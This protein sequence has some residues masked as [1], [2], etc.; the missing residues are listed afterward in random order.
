MSKAIDRNY[1]LRLFLAVVVFLI[2]SIG[3]AQQFDKKNSASDQFILRC[4]GSDVAAVVGRHG[5]ELVHQV[6]DGSQAVALVRSP[7]GV[8]T[9][10]LVN[11]LI[12]DSAVNGV[13]PAQV[14]SL[15]EHGALTQLEGS[16]GE[17]T[18]GLLSQGT[19]SSPCVDQEFSSPVWSGYADQWAAEKLNLHQAH[20][21]GN[22]C[23]NAVLAVID[24]GIDPEHE[25]LEGS[26]ISGFDFIL[27]EAGFASDWSNLEQS[28]TA[29]V[30]QSI[31][32]LVEQSIT[33]LVE[34]IGEPLV[35]E[36]SITA[37]VEQSIT[38]L[39]EG[40]TLPP[41]FGHGDRKSVV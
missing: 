14:A 19:F 15:P 12:L 13:E 22:D 1:P 24:T 10:D 17:L 5:L 21:A 40:E 11:S 37:L 4:A 39:V 16:E 2:A 6:R 38:A 29:L 41:A 30:E 25:L 3:S 7:A 18:L 33:A 35:V 23:G 36:Q 32:A 34:G 26:V 27:N 31:T 8:D 9:E 28:I 20:L